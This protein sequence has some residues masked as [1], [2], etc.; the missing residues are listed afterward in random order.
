M[1]AIPQVLRTYIKGLK[2]HDVP[3]ITATVPDDVR[4]ITPVAAHVATWPLI[5]LQA[6]TCSYGVDLV[7]AV[8]PLCSRG[9][10]AK[11][12]A[13]FGPVLWDDMVS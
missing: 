2:A 1:K 10:V 6:L 5:F 12:P 7:P 9:V 3:K 8:L 13:Q 4:F 11:P